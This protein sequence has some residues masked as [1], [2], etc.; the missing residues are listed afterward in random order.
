MKAIGPRCLEIVDTLFNDGPLDKLRAVQGIVTLKDKYP[1]ARVEA[2]CDRA[3]RFG[4]P[5]CKRVRTILAAGTDLEPVEKVVQL[6]LVS[7]DFARGVRRD[8]FT[9][10]EM[11]C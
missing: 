10:E 4:D 3:I 8:F 9:P 7:Y 2:A 1:T 5:S 11:K 6:K